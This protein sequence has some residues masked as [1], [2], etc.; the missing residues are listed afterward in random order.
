MKQWAV[1]GVFYIILWLLLKVLFQANTI[2]RLR[3]EIKNDKKLQNTKM[4]K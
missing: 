2:K 3:E 1:L 4:G